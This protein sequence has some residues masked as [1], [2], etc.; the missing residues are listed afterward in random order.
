VLFEKIFHRKTNVAILSTA[1]VMIMLVLLF[2]FIRKRWRED[3]YDPLSVAVFG[4]CL[5]MVSD[6]FSPVWRFQYYTLQ[7]LCPVLLVAS[8]YKP[9]QRKWFILLGVALVLNILNIPFVKM[10]HTIGE[11][12]M[13]LVLLA[14]S[15][16]PLAT[17]KPVARS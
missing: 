15:F 14:A 17:P 2:V 9:G 4:F 8:A 12:L 10:E 7:W 5:Y 6:L 1:S 16:G 13:L 3:G 11:Y